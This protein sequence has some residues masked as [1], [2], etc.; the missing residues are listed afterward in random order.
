[1]CTHTRIHGRRE[2]QQG[3]YMGGACL[4][5][6]ELLSF[7]FLCTCAWTEYSMRIYHQRSSE[8]A[9]ACGIGWQWIGAWTR[10][11]HDVNVLMWTI[12]WL[13]QTLHN[14]YS[15]MFKSWMPGELNEVAMFEYLDGLERWFQYRACTCSAYCNVSHSGRHSGH[16]TKVS[17]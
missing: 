10:I 17:A 15:E 3:L 7:L 2:G 9:L 4:W 16:G 5:Y 13:L 6:I 8:T 14:M 1:M 12:T 11:F